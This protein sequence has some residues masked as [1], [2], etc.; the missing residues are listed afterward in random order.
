M[1]AVR[2]CFFSV[3]I[4]VYNRARELEVAL[5]SVLEQN[6]KNMEII[7]VDDGSD[8]DDPACV[9]ESFN[10][11]R[12]KLLRKLN[13]GG[14][15]A[16]NQG[17]MEAVGKYI[18]FLDSDDKFVDGHLLRLKSLFLSYPEV[19]AYSQVV[20][21]R[22]DGIEFLK[23][24]R[25]IGENEEMSEYLLC[26]RGFVQTS[27]LAVP[28][29]LAKK[30]K[31]DESLPYGQDTDFAIRLFS[32][33]IKF[34]MLKTPGAV[35]NDTSAAGRVSNFSRSEARME[36]LG[37]VRGNITKKACYGDMGWPV[38]KFLYREGKCLRALMYYLRAVAYRCYGPKLAAVVLL[39]IVLSDRSYRKLADFL[40][41]RGAKP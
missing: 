38:A 16:R 20:V 19:V 31:Y 23:P 14:G 30:V 2:E 26:D 17:I 37:R 5:S 8:S 21:N 24:P 18:C 32:E 28:A 39:Q 40:A 35:W 13:G 22:G 3:I 11:S 25:A 15:A 6:F 10:D 29:W 33:G 41:R 4:P 1:S 9:V 27:T 12:I 36:W 7:V 34:V